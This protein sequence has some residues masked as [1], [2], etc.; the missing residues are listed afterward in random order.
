M[1]P[2]DVLKKAVGLNSDQLIVLCKQAFKSIPSNDS[3]AIYS[4][5]IKLVNLLIGIPEPIPPQNIEAA[6]TVLR[7]MESA[8]QG[9]HDSEK[10]VNTQRNLGFAFQIRTCGNRNQNLSQAKLHYMRALN[11]LPEKSED[12][13]LMSAALSEVCS[14]MRSP[15]LSKNTR[16][17]IVYLEGALSV[18][19]KEKYPNEFTEYSAALKELRDLNFTRQPLP[20]GEKGNQKRSD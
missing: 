18:Y 13:A 17:A 4:F 10:W 15:S 8:L 1:N 9:S 5:G 3:Q 20:K 6:L 19:T 14:E 12:W 7:R 2:Q 11:A 16:E